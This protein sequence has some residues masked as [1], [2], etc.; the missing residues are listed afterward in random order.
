MVTTVLVGIGIGLVIALIVVFIMK[1]QLKS[2]DFEYTAQEYEVPGTFIVTR[3]N[4]VYL[5][6]NTT[7]V[8][9]PDND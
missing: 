3:S 7:K 9:K 8:K 6:K 2:V 4:D 5:Y 1:S